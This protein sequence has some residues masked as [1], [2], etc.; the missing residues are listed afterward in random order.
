[1]NKNTITALVL[2]LLVIAGFTYFSQPSKEQLVRQQQV[3]DSI[4]AVQKKQQ[5]ANATAEATKDSSATSATDS[6]ATF[7]A[8]HNAQNVVLKNKVLKLTFSTKGGTMTEGELLQY[9]D[10]QQHNVKLFNAKD[11]SLAFLIDGKSENINTSEL[12]F[13]PMNVTDSTVT[14]RLQTK[15]G[16]IDFN[17]ALLG[18]TYMVNFTVQAHGMEGFFSSTTNTMNIR[19]N[20]HIRQQEKGFKFENYRSSLTYKKK[21]SSSDFLNPSSEKEETLKDPLD[22]IAFKNQF[23]SW[24]FIAGN[25]FTQAHIHSVPEENEEAGYL[26]KYDAAAQTFFDPSGKQ[27]T[28][29][30]FFIGPNNYRLLQNMNQ[31]SVN[32]KDIELEELVYLGWP[33]FKWINRWFTIYVFDWLTGIGLNMGI[34]LLL[35]TILLKVIT[36]P[37]MLKSYL[38]SVKMK[39]LRPKMDEISK[40]YPNP[41]DNMKKQQ[42]MMGLYSQYGVS[43]MG[44]CLPML[45]QTPVWIAMFNFIPNAIELRGQS[46]LWSNDLSAYDDLIS[47]ST[48]LPLIGNHLSLFCL[49][50]CA[51]NVINTVISMKQQQNMPG[52]Q[53]QMKMMKYMFYIMPVVFFFVF[54]DYSSGLSYYYFVSGLLSILLMWY[55][56]K[57]INEKKI[58][59]KLEENY[60]KYKA[61]PQKRGGFMAR[62][63]ALQ[64]QQKEM[65]EQQKKQRNK[66]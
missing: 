1:M 2:M 8:P 32:Q 11:A 23:F 13:A 6:S 38:S 55:M 35:I 40:K 14:M 34:V 45:I 26:K 62:M 41:D 7:T 52:Q 5:Q 22:W 20:D 15:Q 25:D 39:V 65:M 61:D 27:P 24:V 42:E 10:Q 17:Y 58:L 21:G 51:T 50:F 53:E 9:K 46:F 60:K 4:A 29:M 56:R 33:L 49:L 57:T 3:Q 44:G 59:A 37:A 64:E 16:Y 43:P 18:N 36:Y 31:Y 19:W 48:H 63:A 47:W 54:N 66:R 30:Q 28:Q 12:Y